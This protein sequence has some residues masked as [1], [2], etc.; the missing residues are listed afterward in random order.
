MWSVF[1]VIL[2]ES[3]KNHSNTPL[4]IPLFYTSRPS[5]N[6]QIQKRLIEP[7]SDF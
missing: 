4:Q 7:I 5:P 2:V 3:K 6:Q 1:T